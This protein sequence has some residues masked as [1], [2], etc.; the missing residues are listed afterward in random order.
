MPAHAVRCYQTMS[1]AGV[2][3]LTGL[4]SQVES[5]IHKGTDYAKL[6]AKKWRR[7]DKGIILK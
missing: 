2:A 3:T 1:E 7:E 6:A 4:R 5:V